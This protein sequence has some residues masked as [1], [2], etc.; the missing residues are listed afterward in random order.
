[1]GRRYIMVQAD[2]DEDVLKQI[3]DATGGQYFRATDS[4]SLKAIFERIDRMEKTEIRSRGYTRH[5]EKV[6]AFLY[7]GALLIGLELL[8]GATLMRRIP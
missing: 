3:A 7:P 2:I 5:A 4:R 8:L 1:M 6:D